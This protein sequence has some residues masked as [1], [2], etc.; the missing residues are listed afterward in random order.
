MS[1]GLGTSGE[2]EPAAPLLSVRDLSVSVARADRN[3]ERVLDGVSLEIRR[4][5]AMAVVGESGSGKTMTALTVMRLLPRGARIDGG[6]IMFR[7]PDEGEMDLAAAEERDVRRLRGRRIAMIFQEPMTSLNPALTI[8]EQIIEAIR[9]HERMPQAEA[10]RRAAAALDEMDVPDAA[11]RLSDHPHQFSGGMRQ[12][13]LVA[14]A[15]ASNP[16]LLLADEPTT[17][18]DASLRI[19]TLEML[20]DLQ[21]RRGM[22]TALITHDLGLVARFADSACVMWGGRV[23]ER[24][25]AAQMLESPLHPYTHALLA[26]APTGDARRR[27]PTVAEVIAENE[28]A[29][30]DGLRPWWPRGMPPNGVAALDGREWVMVEAAPGRHVAA[31][32]TESAVAAAHATLAPCG[33]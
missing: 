26:C 16:S 32:R 6:A 29:A 33:R 25:P 24:G 12:R 7:P 22:A 15:L 19:R 20:R 27:L 28:R 3:R 31:W 18:L 13:V 2:T 17:A 10:K 21:R 11:R 5:E 1:H 23:L 4:G 8:G 9:A 14:M 30:S